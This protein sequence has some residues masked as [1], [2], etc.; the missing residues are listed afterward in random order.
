MRSRATCCLLL[1]ATARDQ[2]VYQLFFFLKMCFTHSQCI[3]TYDCVVVVYDR[4]TCRMASL[5]L[6]SSS[7]S[8]SSSR[9]RNAAALIDW[10]RVFISS[11]E[12]SGSDPKRDA[13][14]KESQSDGA[15][16]EPEHDRGE[17]KRSGSIFENDPQLPAADVATATAAAAGGQMVAQMH[18]YP[19]KYLQEVPGYFAHVLRADKP[20]SR[21]RK[22]HERVRPSRRLA[23]LTV[24]QMR[25][26]VL[27]LHCC[28]QGCWL[29]EKANAD[30]MQEDR[31][32]LWAQNGVA[33]RGR[34]LARHINE[35]CKGTYTVQ[36]WTDQHYVTCQL[37][38]ARAFGVS[39]VFVRKHSNVQR[40]VPQPPGQVTVSS[41]ARFH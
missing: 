16:V 23:R 10:S 5:S 37:F 17:S 36:P 31:M 4:F 7:S 18:R 39:H 19:Y 15:E 28:N 2:D 9:K 12:E 34:W 6:S 26:E 20:K 24:D 13:P 40:A 27:G 8:G 33:A 41:I 3:R 38:F 21:A 1:L 32:K 14:R 11:D 22:R 30:V 29:N 35:T 25:N